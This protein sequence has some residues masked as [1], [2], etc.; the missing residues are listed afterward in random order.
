MI[1]WRRRGV[2]HKLAC[3]GYDGQHN[4]DEF[5]MMLAH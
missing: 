2:L 1:R 5:S 3:C 4:S